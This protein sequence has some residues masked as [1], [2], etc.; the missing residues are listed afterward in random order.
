MDNLNKKI[1]DLGDKYIIKYNKLQELLEK[2]SSLKLKY[3]MNKLPLYINNN[4]DKFKK[5][6]D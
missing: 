2:N 6:I 1:I 5:W 3:D 4:L